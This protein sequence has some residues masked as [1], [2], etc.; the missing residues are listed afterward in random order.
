MPVIG[1]LDEQVEDVLIKPA[2]RRRDRQDARDPQKFPNRT[3]EAA[4]EETEGG[5]P[6]RERA[7]LP[8]WLL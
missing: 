6:K 8:V 1:R 2:S 7:D 3:P 4:P 5:A